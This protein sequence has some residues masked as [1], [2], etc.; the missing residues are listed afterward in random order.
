MEGVNVYRDGDNVVVGNYVNG[1]IKGE[2]GV[3]FEGQKVMMVFKVGSG[4]GKGMRREKEL[5]VLVKKYENVTA[6]SVKQILE[7][8]ITSS[9]VDTYLNLPQYLSKSFTSCRHIHLQH[10]NDITYIGLHPDAN[11]T[12]STLGIV[13]NDNNFIYK[14][15]SLNR[16]KEAVG[17]GGV[18]NFNESKEGDFE[19]DDVVMFRESRSEEVRGIMK[20][21]LLRGFGWQN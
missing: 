6:E 8:I 17:I 11:T 13:F 5:P 10:Y 18:Y 4:S 19:I 3:I 15:G 1:E 12:P 16:E 2:I 21:H 20:R 7:S 9:S 14:I